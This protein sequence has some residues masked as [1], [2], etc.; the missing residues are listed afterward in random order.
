L[1]AA[2]AGRQGQRGRARGARETHRRGRRKRSHDDSSPGSLTA[3]SGR[4]FGRRTLIMR[5]NGQSCAK[6][7]TGR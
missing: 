5:S 4:R 1:G 3:E 6:T 2:E 7:G